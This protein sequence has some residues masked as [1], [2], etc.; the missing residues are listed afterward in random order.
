[1]KKIGVKKERK[2]N[3]CEEMKKKKRSSCEETKKEKRR[4]EWRWSEKKNWR[5]N[6]ACDLKKKGR[7]KEK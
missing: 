3:R 5:E 6:Q 2:K 1:M 7:K 4:E